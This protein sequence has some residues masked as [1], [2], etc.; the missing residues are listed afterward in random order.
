MWPKRRKKHD[1]GCTYDEGVCSCG[2]EQEQ[3]CHDAFMAVINSKPKE[4]S[5]YI[6]ETPHIKG[7]FSEPIVGGHM[8][9]NGDCEPQHS[10]PTKDTCPDCNGRGAY[11]GGI[12]NPPVKCGRCGGTGSIFNKKSE[13]CEHERRCLE[14]KIKLP[15]NW[16]P[17]FCPNCRKDKLEPQQEKE[18]QQRLVPLDEKEVA[19]TIQ[20]Y[21][22]VVEISTEH[23]KDEFAK[24]AKELVNYSM[25]HGLAKVICQKFGHAVVSVPSV[26]KS[27]LFHIFEDL[28]D[29]HIH[30]YQ[31]SKIVEGCYLDKSINNA[32]EAIK[33][34]I[35]GGRI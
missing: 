33:N 18:L 3:A 7:D 9:E 11:G 6:T 2:L 30:A 19:K 23:F 26:D 24:L 20:T 17:S 32:T 1:F 22:G 29:D 25:T 35:D 4:F 34:L 27:K 28:I 14:C 5:G 16:L 31:N 12:T 10:E 8:A 15:N 21:F 13:T